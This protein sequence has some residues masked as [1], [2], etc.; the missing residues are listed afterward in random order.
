MWTRTWLIGKMFMYPTRKTFFK[1]EILTVICVLFIWPLKS[2]SRTEWGGSF[3]FF[4]VSCQTF[5]LATVGGFDKLVVGQTQHLRASGCIGL[6]RLR[7]R[8][9][10]GRGGW[11]RAPGGG[12]NEVRGDPELARTACCLHLQNARA[13]AA[14]AACGLPPGAGIIIVMSSWPVV[15]APNDTSTISPTLSRLSTLLR[16]EWQASTFLPHS[17][18]TCPPPCSLRDDN[19]I[20][21]TY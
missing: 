3:Y 7:G 13:T 12:G 5:W 6:L 20:V 21:D 17:C 14:A 19:N 15:R 1:H 8:R 10:D 16:A 2:G 4:K 9:G 18:A 11:G